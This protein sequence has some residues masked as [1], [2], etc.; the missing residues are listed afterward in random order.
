MFGRYLKVRDVCPVCA[1]EMHHHRADDAPPYFT[2]MI[3]GH[4]LVPLALMLERA[5]APPLWL[6]FS[7]L[8]PLTL[9]LTLLL[10]PRVKGALIGLQWANRMHGFG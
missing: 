1:L 7:L 8:L 5:A 9:I 2:M 3:L 4:I 10:L 6:H